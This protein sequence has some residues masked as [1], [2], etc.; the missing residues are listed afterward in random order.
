LQSYEKVL[1]PQVF[2]QYFSNF[3]TAGF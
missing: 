1:N 3:S 2:L